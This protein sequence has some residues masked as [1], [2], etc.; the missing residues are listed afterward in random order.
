[1][2]KVWDGLQMKKISVGLKERGYDVL[3]GSGAVRELPSVVEGLSKSSPVVIITDRNVEACS[4]RIVSGALKGVRR[5]VVKIVLEPGERT[6][7]FSVFAATVRKIASQTRGHKPV[8]VALGGGVVG[9]LAGFVA[10]A[11]RRGV[12]LVQVP[13]TLLA[14]VD[15]SVGGKV[16]IDIPEGKNIVGAF[17]HPAAVLSDTRFLSSLDARQI[18]NGMAEIIKYAAISSPEMFATLEKSMRKVKFLDAKF[19]ESIVSRCVGIK[20]KI[21]EKDE[22]DR[23]DVRIVLNFGHTLG[24][25]VEAAS[26][27]SHRYNHGES[28]SL[29]MVMAG[30]IAVRLGIFGSR[31]QRKL[32]DILVSA[33][34]PVRVKDVRVSKVLAA[35]RHDKKFISG[36]NRFVLPS[37]IGKVKVVEGVPESIVED[38]VRVLCL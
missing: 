20:A 1:M 29:G 25:A 23:K 38:T 24:H 21:V 6:K 17:Y 14:Q 30:E 8:I 13:T 18:R 28:V 5:P 22:F 15:S 4:G 37:A 35:Y 27:Y 3:I 2:P 9:D 33:G 31:A 12:P 34:L 32:E 11:Y 26:G 36:V 7:R 19:M 10:S 16:G